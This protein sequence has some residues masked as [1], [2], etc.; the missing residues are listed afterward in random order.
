MKKN[1]K[2]KI[3][4]ILLEKYLLAILLFVLIVLMTVIKYTWGTNNWWVKI[5]PSEISSS[6]VIGG[7]TY[8]IKNTSV[9]AADLFI[10]TKIPAGV[11][12]VKDEKAPKIMPKINFIVNKN[13]I[14][15]NIFSLAPNLPTFLNFISADNQS[16]NIVFDAPEL[17]DANL[18]IK[19]GGSN[20]IIFNIPVS[21]EYQFHCAVPG[22]QEET[23]KMIVK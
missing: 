11:E 20:G 12:S 13:N 6:V 17:Q 3:T 16:H 2:Q 8:T 10:P 23:G 22:H 4:K 21:G 5:N 18:D 14:S 7:A 15:P 9:I 19:A 1:K